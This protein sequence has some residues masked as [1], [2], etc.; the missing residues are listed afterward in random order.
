MKP[1]SVVVVTL[2]ILGFAS[3]TSAQEGSEPVP[4]VERETVTVNPKLP[5]YIFEIE[6][7]G[8]TN[9][10]IRI[11]GGPKSYRGQTIDADVDPHDT[12]L[13]IVDVNFDGYQDFRLHTDESP[14][15]ND[16]YEYWVFDRKTGEFKEAP[17]FDDITSVDEAHKLLITYSRLSEFEDTTEYYRVEDGEPVEIKSVETAWSK[18]VR[19]IVPASYSDFTGVQITR[20]YRNGRV[21]RTFYSKVE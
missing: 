6:H 16:S 18:N 12:D 8:F 4:K 10:T 7:K 15:G 19:D 17:D 13:D 1:L 3:I 21:Y 14:M 9:V 2:I 5:P 11:S 20:L